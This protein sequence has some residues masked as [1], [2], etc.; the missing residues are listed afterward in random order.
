MSKPV[1]QADLDWF[2]PIEDETG[3]LGASSR[4]ILNGLESV[5]IVEDIGEDGGE[6][7]E[8]HEEQRSANRISRTVRV[9]PFEILFI[10][11]LDGPIAV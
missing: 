6:R 4:E 9:S 10:E 1:L 7:Y 3:A 2:G 5:E 11:V 8:L